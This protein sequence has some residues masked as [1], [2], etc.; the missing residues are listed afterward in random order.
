MKVKQKLSKFIGESRAK[1]RIRISNSIA[2]SHAESK[3]TDKMVKFANKYHIML[4]TT[5]EQYVSKEIKKNDMIGATLYRFGSLITASRLFISSVFNNPT[6]IGIMCDGNYL[7]ANQRV[8]SMI[9]SLGAW[10]ILFIGVLLQINEINYKWYLLTFIHDWKHRRLLPLNDKNRNRLAM[11]INLMAKLLMKQAF[12][13][14]VIST[15]VTFIAPTFVAYYQQKYPMFIIPLIFFNICML[16]WIFQFYCIVCA[17]FVAWSVPF[18]YFKYKFREICEGMAICVKHNNIG[19][20]KGLISQHQ[21]LAIQ[22][23]LIDDVFMFVVFILYYVASP[24]LLLLLY[25]SHAKGT[26]NFVRPIFIFIQ[27]MVYFVVCYLNFFCAQISHL[28]AKPRVLMFKYLIEHD[29]NIKDRIK[30]MKF[31][32]KLSESNIGF[33][34]WTLFPMNNYTFYK[35]VANCACT[36]FL[37]LGLVQQL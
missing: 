29:I 15:S 30:I 8:F 18:F 22:T 23:K 27:S 10:V 21:R 11:I 36:Y 35:Y 19:I 2:G 33:N 7:L 5:I 32:E 6:M 24:A 37:I 28:A 14:L 16:I 31:I 3:A 9:I 34:N 26:V 13:P 12:W 17:G 1:A 25:L 20:L 4:S